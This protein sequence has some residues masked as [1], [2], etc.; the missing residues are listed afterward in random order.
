MPFDRYMGLALYDPEVGYYRQP[1]RRV[2]YGE[3]SDFYTA[4]TSGAIFGELVVAAACTLLEGAD[5]AAFT[6]IEIGAEPAADG[7]AGGIMAGVSH[8]FRAARTVRIGEPLSLEGPCVVF[9]NELLDAQPFRRVIRRDGRWRECGVALID[10]SLR[11]VERGNAPAEGLPED[12]SD[13]Y[14]LDLPEA[15]GRL[16][17]SIA[18]QPWTGLFIAIDY[19]KSWAELATETPGGTA[20]AYHRHTQSNDLLAHPGEQDLTCH[21]CWDWVSAALTEHRF[22]IP[23][24]ESQEAFFVRRAA[25]Y[26]QQIL[27]IDPGTSTPR[28][29]SLMQLLHPA[30]LGH[31]F[32]VLHTRREHLSLSP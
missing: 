9:S 22:S 26:L 2:G 7:S 5:P 25:K 28:K 20:R 31:K 3:A 12:V 13:G 16:V 32:Q 24:I 1:R 23:A 15:A 14:R 18:S 21:I 19:G 17:D 8:P 10:G 27:A 6:F 11:E 30:H 4:S 29:R